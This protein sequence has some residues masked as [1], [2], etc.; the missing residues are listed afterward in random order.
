MLRFVTV[1]FQPCPVFALVG[2]EDSVAEGVHG[3]RQHP[4]EDV[5]WVP[6]VG[7]TA[8]DVFPVDALEP[9]FGGYLPA[10]LAGAGDV[11][12]P[13][14]EPFGARPVVAVPLFLWGSAPDRLIFDEHEVFR[15]G[16]DVDVLPLVERDPLG[17]L[18]RYA[19]DAQCPPQAE[20][21]VAVARTVG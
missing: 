8:I 17:G 14:E 4:L 7:E 13:R 6:F 5:I 3:L 20:R 10:V 2:V 21:T 16:E 9:A 18:Q 12:N 11:D 1:T 19:G 15:A